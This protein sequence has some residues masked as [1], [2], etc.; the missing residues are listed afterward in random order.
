MKNYGIFGSS[1][2]PSKLGDTVRGL[3]ISLSAV[4]IFVASHFNVTLDQSQV[5]E[6]A[7]V[8][9]GAVGAIWTLYGL[10]KKLIVKFS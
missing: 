10:V 3:I 7:T 4:L 9:G 2:D 8:L 6:I 1:E 5:V